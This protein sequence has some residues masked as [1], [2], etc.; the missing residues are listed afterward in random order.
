[1]RWLGLA[2]ASLQVR[3]TAI[4]SANACTVTTDVAMAEKLA[5]LRARGS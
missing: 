2:K 5:V 3:L 4:A 1:M